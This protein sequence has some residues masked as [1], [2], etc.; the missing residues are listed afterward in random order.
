MNKRCIK[1]AK[2]LFIAVNILISILLLTAASSFWEGSSSTDTYGILPDRGFYVATSFFP[3]NTVVD[4]TNLENGRTIQAI[5]AGNLSSPGTSVLLSRDA[6]ESLSSGNR[7]STRIRMSSPSDSVAFSRFSDG[8]SFS[9]DPDYDPKA[10]IKEN[11]LP[12]QTQA[13]SAEP[14]YDKRET[15]PY[16]TYPNSPPPVKVIP[17]PPDPQ[18]DAAAA[19]QPLPAYEISRTLPPPAAPPEPVTIFMPAPVPTALTV[20]EE[21]EDVVETAVAA[22][23]EIPEVYSSPYPL[24]PGQYIALTSPDTPTPFTIPEPEPENPF[25]DV[26]SPYPNPIDYSAQPRLVLDEAEI[27]EAYELAAADRREPGKVPEQELPP[28]IVLPGLIPKE[29]GQVA[30]LTDAVIISPYDMAETPITETPTETPVIP[31][32][33]QPGTIPVETTAEITLAEKDDESDFIPDVS[34]PGTPPDY[35]GLIPLTDASSPSPMD[36]FDILIAEQE[37]TLTPDTISPALFPGEE[38]IVTLT[39]AT[40]PSPMDVFDILIAEQEETLTPDTISPALFP[41]EEEIAVLTDDVSLSMDIFEEPDAVYLTQLPD[42]TE[43]V[44]LGDA[45]YPNLDKDILPDVSYPGE[46]PAGIIEGELYDAVFRAGSVTPEISLSYADPGTTGTIELVDGNWVLK[47]AAG[48]EYILGAE[49][50]DAAGDE[51][52]LGAEAS[53]YY[54][55]PGMTGTIELVDGY[56]VLKDA[57]GGEYILGAE[58]SPYYAEP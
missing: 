25:P 19:A 6:A 4:I 33:I 22:A 45:P 44:P 46:S 20:E 10:F 27:G 36:V 18:K 9:G 39:D 50:T 51:F 55:E 26:N 49:A 58:A 48:G 43:I 32:V 30:A 7:T 17:D 13:K 56:W 38:K 14:S 12:L 11:F 37:E 34:T 40:S 15:Y 24:S 16:G 53:P 57:A 28:E 29:T 5:V 23:P 21:T 35:T 41:G 31:E 1:N 52:L 8:R 54:A 3:R 47:D 42:G 2:K